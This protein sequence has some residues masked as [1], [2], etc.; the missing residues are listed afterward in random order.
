MQ[1]AVCRCGSTV[2]SSPSKES[3]PNADSQ[4]QRADTTYPQK[5]YFIPRII[6]NSPLGINSTP[7]GQL[8]KKINPPI[9]G[10]KNH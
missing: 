6:H 3:K 1:A 2:L 7:L 9:G 8:V 5:R 10:S 4:K